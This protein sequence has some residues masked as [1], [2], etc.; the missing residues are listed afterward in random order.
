MVEQ[1]TEDHRV[2]GS[3]P[4]LSTKLVCDICGKPSVVFD[5]WFNY[6]PCEDHKH[7]SPSEYSQFKNKIK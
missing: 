7:L 3:N 5:S 2:E 4:S 1:L 6:Y